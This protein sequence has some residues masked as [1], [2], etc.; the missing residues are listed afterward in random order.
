[1]PY[2]RKI[3]L[4]RPDA[5]QSGSPRVLFWTGAALVL[6]FT[7]S[8]IFELSGRHNFIGSG[9]VAVSSAVVS[10]ARY[11][12][13]GFASLGLVFKLKPIIGEN[14]ELEAQNAAL[15]K[16]IG[17]L[18]AARAE[19]E[20][21]RRLLK[22]P[23]ISKYDYLAAKIVGRSLELWFDSVWINRGT[24]DGIRAGDLVINVDG[25]VGEIIHTEAGRSQI[26]LIL[27]PDFA[28]GAITAKSRQQGVVTGGKR[29]SLAYVNTVELAFVAKKNRIEVGE[30][31]F[32]SGL[33]TGRPSGVYIG[34]VT[35][36]IE[37]PNRITQTIEVTPAVDLN[38][39][40]EVIIILH[41][42]PAPAPLS[43]P[44]PD[45]GGER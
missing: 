1:M 30:K 32:T 35:K 43:T 39:L 29:G 26:R 33:A 3:R 15:R 42:P 36:V 28:I 37:E 12:G 5:K 6:M 13:D 19:N 22:L 17:E 27:N 25:L 11:I 4:V 41:R 45:E 21:L 24:R 34:L 14:I 16:Q 18:E 10:G 40:E 44:Q 7:L 23:E 8:L 38:S 20:R 2:R 31:V 9:I